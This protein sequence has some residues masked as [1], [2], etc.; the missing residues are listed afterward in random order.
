MINRNFLNADRDK[1]GKIEKDEYL[2]LKNSVKD[3][4]QNQNL[5]RSDDWIVLKCYRLRRK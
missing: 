2:A 3:V 4:A 5:S 1:N